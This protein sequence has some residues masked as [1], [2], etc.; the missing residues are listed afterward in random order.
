MHFNDWPATG[1]EAD[2]VTRTCRVQLQVEPLY[3]DDAT[4]P[5]WKGATA[6]AFSL[7]VR[8]SP[9]AITLPSVPTD[10]TI[11][12]PTTLTAEVTGLTFGQTPTVPAGSV[13]FSLGRQA[14]N[15][16]E[17]VDIPTGQQGEGYPC[18]PRTLCRA[19]LPAVANRSSSMV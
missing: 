12:T 19:T 13:A 9:T 5:D 15:S 1:P 8:R 18:P 7:P 3:S 6:V 17:S 10:A 14:S 4:K 16:D 11:T 2:A